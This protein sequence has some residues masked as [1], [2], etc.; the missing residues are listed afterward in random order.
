MEIV[1]HTTEWVNGEV[2]QGKI[3]LVIGAL[4]LVAWVAI[5]RSQHELLRGI[6]IP[7]TLIIVATTG[8]GSFQVIG[9]PSHISK[10]TEVA[11]KDPNAAFDMEMAKSQNDHRVYSYLTTVW[12][13]LIAA[14]ALVT[15]FLKGDFYKGL[16]IGL[17]ALF[18]AVLILDS[19]LHYRLQ[20]Y[21]KAL[22]Q[23]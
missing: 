6:M 10:V 8:Y 20:H 21:I 17:M 15:L 22:E 9:R 7:M 2:L 1:K 16:G 14:S 23:L 5:F 19:T 11:K 12:I 13:I 18:L 4:L 3:M